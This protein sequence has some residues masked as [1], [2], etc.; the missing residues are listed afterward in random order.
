MASFDIPSPSRQIY[1]A[2][3]LD[4]IRSRG[5]HEALS[6]AV[7]VIPHADL[8]SEI[9]AYAPSSAL[10]LLQGTSVRDEEVFAT[11][12]VLKENPHL[13]GYYRLLLGIS[14]KEFYKNKTG[15]SP[16]KRMEEKGDLI[17]ATSQIL[18]DF[19][20]AFNS[21]VATLLH[22]LPQGKLRQDV[23]HLPLL[24]LGAQAD[25]SWRGKIGE[26]ATKGVFEAMK[27]IVKNAKRTYA[28][29]DVSITV[30]NS[31]GREVTL[32]LAPDPDIVIREDMGTVSV[33]KAAIEIKGG[34]DY[35]NVHNRAGEAEK[36]HQKA[37][38][39]GAQNCWTIITMDPQ[40]DV[41]KIKK[42]SPTTA[43]WFHLDDVLKQTGTDWARL[44]SLTRSAMG[45]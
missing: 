4:D 19:C 5:L 27:L 6:K 35:A 32:S 3:F 10:Q 37:R 26:K 9:Q 25:G 1:M 18:P 36:S 43:E 41:A 12:C 34:T 23:N 45:I 13:V 17:D 2:A 42:E 15:C 11:P 7:A 38:N 39:D 16:L 29:T 20:K 44:D 30:T 31:S 33:F 28:E 22:A 21:S 14:Q 40:L 24:S 8:S